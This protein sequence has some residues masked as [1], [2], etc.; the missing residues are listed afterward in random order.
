MSDEVRSL[1]RRYRSQTFGE[2]IGQEH[3]SRTLLNALASGRIGHAY[4]F[5]GPRGSGKTSTARILAKAVN[6]LTNGGRGEPC[7]ECEMCRAINEGRALDLI[8]IDAASNRGIDEIRDLRDKVHFAPTQARYKVYILDEAHMLTNEAFNALLKTLEEP[9]AHVIFALVTTEAH[10]IPP[11]ILSRCQRFDFHRASMN[12][13]LAKLNRICREEQIKA[14]PAALTVIARTA[15]GSYRDA[16]SLLDQLASFTGDAGVTLAYVQ[17]VLGL[18][19]LDATGKLVSAIARRDVAG[20]LQLLTQIVQGGA[21]LRQFGRDLVDY[22]R[23]LM[24]VKTGN[25]NLLDTTPDAIE[26]MRDQARALTIAD[27]VRLIKLFSDPDVASGLRASAQPQLPLELAF[28]EACADAVQPAMSDAHQRAPIS[29][30]VVGLAAEQ[31]PAAQT[32]ASAQTATPSM[33]PTPRA[34]AATR[35]AERTTP[36]SVSRPASTPPARP[37]TSPS[38][39]GSQPRAAV[40][41]RPPTQPIVTAPPGSPLANV[42]EKWL[43][44]LETVKA[45]SRSVEAF[46]KDCRPIEVNDETIVLAF[47]HSFHKDSVDNMKHRALVEESFSRVLAQPVRIRCVLAPD[48]APMTGG[49]TAGGRTANPADDAVV[50][51]AEKLFGAK[52]VNVE[53][54]DD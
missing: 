41:P 26:G 53:K 20:G 35:S 10:K 51:E 36:A 16:E 7:N 46:L 45:S 37:V 39:V 12:D 21:D 9:P 38:Y 2:L 24:L 54:P 31:P 11:T 4:L 28:I 52:V 14:E 6:C 25:E 44:I 40:T 17:Q 43:T 32:M 13:I 1:Y 8:E 34:A 19:P 42:Q 27:L 50:K 29:G 47:K 3:V 49:T 18:A 30:T 22:L 5:A 23:D 48:A 15:T 33:P